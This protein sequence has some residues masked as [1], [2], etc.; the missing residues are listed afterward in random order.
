MPRMFIEIDISDSAI[1]IC[2]TGRLSLLVS[3]FANSIPIMIRKDTG[4][5]AMQCKL[6]TCLHVL[7]SDSGAVFTFGKSKFAD[8]LPNKFWV[9]NDRVLQVACGD[10]HT[11]LVAGKMF[12]P[13]HEKTNNVVSE[14]V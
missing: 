7:V 12:E 2:S 3:Q 6:V 14:K 5:L 10:E 13:R 4:Q 1:C 9:R 8:N 11:A